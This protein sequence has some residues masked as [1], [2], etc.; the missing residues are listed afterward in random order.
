MLSITVWRVYD[1]EV[2]SVG[3]GLGTM[4]IGETLTA[5]RARLEFLKRNK[6]V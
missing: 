1:G 5:S 2:P 3:S 4:N 6:N